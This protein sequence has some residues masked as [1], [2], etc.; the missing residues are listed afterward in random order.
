VFDV[1]THA[2]DLSRATGQQAPPQQLLE[3]ALGV[4]KQ[5]ISSDLRVPG[6]FDAEQPIADSAPLAD[7]LL[8][9]AGRKV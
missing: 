2:T 3:T 7:R 4:G 6:I 1:T 8:A 9:F 5:M